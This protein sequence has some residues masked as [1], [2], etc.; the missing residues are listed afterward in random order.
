MQKNP[1]KQEV[2]LQLTDTM[3]NAGL[4]PKVCSVYF[5]VSEPFGVFGVVHVCDGPSCV[6]GNACG[7]TLIC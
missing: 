1:R 4:V 5:S 2:T 6:Y 7:K 3:V